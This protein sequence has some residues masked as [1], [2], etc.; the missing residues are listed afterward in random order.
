MLEV[1]DDPV[2]RPALGPDHDGVQHQPEE[3][4]GLRERAQLVVVEVACRVVDAAAGPVRVEHRR[5]ARALEDLRERA[6][7]GVREVEDHPQRDEPVD[8]LASEPRE[9]AALL[10]R[11]VGEGIPPVPRQPRH[12]DAERVEDVGGPGLDAEAL[13][14]LE[15]EQQ[16]DPLTRLDRVQ[17]RRGRDLDDIGVAFSER[18]VEGRRER[19][20][21]AKRALR[22]DDDVA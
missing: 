16:P 9:P 22:L 8:E 21:L 4:I 19:E 11:A 2:E 14:A 18:A 6:A 7:R 15:G 12:P 17:I 20:R 13:D 5:A 3:P 10:R 1:V